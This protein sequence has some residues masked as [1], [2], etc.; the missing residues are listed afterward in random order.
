MP[1]RSLQ[2]AS[3]GLFCRPCGGLNEKNGDFSI[4][5]RRL[6]ENIIRNN[7]KETQTYE[8]RPHRKV[9]CGPAAGARYTGTDIQVAIEWQ[10]K[11][12]DLNKRLP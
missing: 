10:F 11:V 3:N 8:T 2:L 1:D 12:S 4:F 6:S 9:C 7:I 5:I